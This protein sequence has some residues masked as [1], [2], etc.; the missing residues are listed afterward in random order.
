MVL[1]AYIHLTCPHSRELLALLDQTGLRESTVVVDAGNT[2]FDTFRHGVLS[3]PSLF[4]DNNLVASGTFE[5]E[6]LRNYLSLFTPVI[7]GDETL[8]HG[9]INAATDNVGIA[10]Y[11]YLYEEPG[12]LFQN[13]DYLLAASGLIWIAVRDRDGFLGKLRALAESNLPGFLIEKPHL[14]YKVIA[15]NFL[16]EVY[17]ATGQTP[18]ENKMRELYTPEMFAHWLF[19]RPAVGRIGIRTESASGTIPSKARA[20]WDYMLGNL[21]ELWPIV[22]KTA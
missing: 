20:V 6:R 1:T 22:R 7:P 12:I 16:R 15:L 9:M 17:W 5:P 13:P 11:L 19:I 10:A 14:F 8:F 3:V 4:A 21:S 2:P 18:D